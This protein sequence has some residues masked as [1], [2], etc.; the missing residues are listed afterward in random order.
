MHSS[1]RVIDLDGSDSKLGHD[2]A[3]KMLWSA[4]SLSSRHWTHGAAVEDLHN[5][6]ICG[7]AT[8]NCDARCHELRRRRANRG[9][10]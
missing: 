9:Q 8:R 10:A 4:A 5:G 3:L 6:Q 1:S 7:L 2:M